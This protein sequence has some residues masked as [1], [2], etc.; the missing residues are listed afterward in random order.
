MRDV[1]G[2]PCGH[3]TSVSRGPLSCEFL[4]QVEAP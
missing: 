4:E 1:E 3:V 2:V